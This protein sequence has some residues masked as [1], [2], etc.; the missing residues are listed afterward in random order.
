MEVARHP[1][2]RRRSSSS[3]C[4]GGGGGRA[5]AEGIHTFW[6]DSCRFTVGLDFNT[7]LLDVSET[8]FWFV[9]Q[10]SC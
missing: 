2:S 9:I 4:G 3:S 10:D 5:A 7:G 8:G 1:H 6:V